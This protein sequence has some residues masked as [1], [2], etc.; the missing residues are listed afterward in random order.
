MHDWLKDFHWKAFSLLMAIGIWLTVRKEAE[1]PAA[2]A[3]TA[4]KNA[5]GNVPVLAVSTSGTV[6]QAQLDPQNVSVTVSGPPETMGSLNAGQ[7]HAFVNVTGFGTAQ[8]LPRDVEIS[9]PPGVAVVE[10]DP[11]QVSVTIT[12]QP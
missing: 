4:T 11:P 6:S 3:P 12:K 10:V 9:L 7:I 2:H 5:Y 1:T 8:N